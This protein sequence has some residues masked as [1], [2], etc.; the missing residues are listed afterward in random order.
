MKNKSMIKTSIY[1]LCVCV[2]VQLFSHIRPF[3]APWTVAHQA[4]LPMEFFKQEFWSGLPFSTPG[5][6]PNAVIEPASS[7]VYPELAGRFFT[8]APPGK[9]C[10]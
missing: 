9:P 1:Y 4:A 2:C 5:D 3:P 10:L 6:T 8:T 7:F